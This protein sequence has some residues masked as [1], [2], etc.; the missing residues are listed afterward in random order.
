MENKH[1]IYKNV[2]FTQRAL[3]G[4]IDATQIC[5]SRE[6]KFANWSR[7]RDAIK[8]LNSIENSVYKSNR[9]TWMNPK[10]VEPL[11]KWVVREEID[12][13]YVQREFDKPFEEKKEEPLATEKKCS[14]CQEILPFACFNKN[15]NKEYGYDNRCRNCYKQDDNRQEYYREK[16]LEYYEE[17]REKCIKQKSEWNK[18]NVERTRE[19]NRRHYAKKKAMKEEED[20]KRAEEE[21]KNIINNIT[22]MDKNNEPYTIICRESDGYIN[23]TNL[24]KAGGREFKTWKKRKCTIE[25]LQVLEEHI[26]K[27]NKNQLGQIFLGEHQDRNSSVNIDNIDLIKFG[28]GDFNIETKQTW[29]HPKVA[30]NIAQWISPK[31]DVQVS[32]WIHQL[33]VLGQVKISD[34]HNDEKLMGIQIGKMKYNRL[35]SEGLD[36]EAEDVGRDVINKI[37]EL[38]NRNKELEDKYSN[39][40]VE[41]KRLSSYLEKK[42]RIQYNKVKCVYIMEH[43]KFENMYKIGIANNLTS[44]MSTYNTSAPEDFEVIFNVHT[45]NNALVEMMVKKKMIEYLYVNNKEWYKVEDGVDILVEAVNSAVKYFE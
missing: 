45:F 30:I 15:K 9:H 22:L 40:L 23:V 4:Y 17:N 25:F 36:E 44:R 2:H 5:Q 26:Q 24:C 20:A 41:I 18:A 29:V 19:T 37:Q 21:A 28:R 6:R 14:K 38:E 16:A 27:E 1:F 39:S 12:F 42:R 3:D 35:I 32:E 7:T 13:S 10:C 8:V 11:L 34:E 43:K 31:F 33:L